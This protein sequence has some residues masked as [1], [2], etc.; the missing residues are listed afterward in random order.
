MKVIP[1]PA[2]IH[3]TV[4]HLALVEQE[5]LQGLPSYGMHCKSQ[6]YV[7]LEHEKLSQIYW[8]TIHVNT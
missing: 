2:H 8:K 5:H 3:G 6:Q 1:W 4:L 7:D